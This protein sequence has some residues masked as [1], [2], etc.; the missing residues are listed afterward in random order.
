MKTFFANGWVCVGPYTIHDL[1]KVKIT[2]GNEEKSAFLD[3]VDGVRVAKVRP[4]NAP[5]PYL[6]K[7]NGQAIGHV[8][9]S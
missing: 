4:P 8:V 6:V 9:V 1:K 5:G 2:V 7:L 3:W